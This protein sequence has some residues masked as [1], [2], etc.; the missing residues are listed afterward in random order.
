MGV[1]ELGELL[2]GINQEIFYLIA[3]IKLEF[4][5]YQYLK[6]INDN[7]ELKSTYITNILKCVPPDDK[8]LSDEILNCSNFLMKKY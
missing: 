7:L 2:P 1:L 8:P 4:Q 6:N 5:I 3:Y